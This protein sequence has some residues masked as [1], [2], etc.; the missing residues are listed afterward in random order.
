MYSRN[1]KN[2]T[3]EYEYLL[4]F[5]MKNYYENEGLFENLSYDTA[6]FLYHQEKEFYNNL[7][8]KLFSKVY[9]KK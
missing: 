9:Q 1:S 5:C 7:E 8:K 2:Y 6:K 4:Y 3:T